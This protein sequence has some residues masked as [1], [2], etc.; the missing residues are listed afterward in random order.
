[1]LLRRVLACVRFSA[2]PAI[3]NLPVAASHAPSVPVSIG[4]SSI[5]TTEI[6][7]SPF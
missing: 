7:F 5:R 1:M 6:T 4:W 3:E 2:V